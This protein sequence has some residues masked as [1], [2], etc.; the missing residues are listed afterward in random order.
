MSDPVTKTY[1]VRVALE[2]IPAEAKLGM[3][4]KVVLNNGKEEHFLLPATAI[5]QT[6]EQA[7]V[8]LVKYN[9][10][11]LTDITIAG[12]AGN[13]VI[14]ASGVTRGDVIVTAGLNKLVPNQD[15]RLMESGERK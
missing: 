4:A 14:V 5:Y 9:K 12:Y 13:D 3:T 10:A 2:Q 11:N 6:N 8:W 7:K 1:R 15:V